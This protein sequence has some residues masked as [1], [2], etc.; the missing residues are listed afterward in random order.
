MVNHKSQTSSGVRSLGQLATI[1]YNDTTTQAISIDSFAAASSI[2][3]VPVLICGMF[4]S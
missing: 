1:K 2:P 3:I 4:L